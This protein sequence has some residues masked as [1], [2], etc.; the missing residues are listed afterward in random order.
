[1]REKCPDPPQALKLTPKYTKQ[2]FPGKTLNEVQSRTAEL[3]RCLYVNDR[4]SERP[5]YKLMDPLPAQHPASPFIIEKRN[6]SLGPD[7]I[8][9]NS[10]GLISPS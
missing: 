10:K 7:E 4:A 9:C 5:G 8:T 3:G 1:M 6:F 2:I